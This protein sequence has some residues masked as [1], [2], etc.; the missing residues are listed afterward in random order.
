MFRRLLERFSRGKFFR[1]RLPSEF[2][3][4]SI[5]V[6]PDSALGYL[7]PWWDEGSAQLMSVAGRFVVPGSTVWDI[8]SNVGVFAIAAAHKA[9]ANS[10]VL[11]VEPDPFLAHLVQRSVL[12]SD[13]RD[14]RISVLCQAI[15]NSS[16]ISRFVIAERGRSTNALEVSRRGT[17]SGGHVPHRLMQYVPTT[18]LDSLRPHFGSPDFIKVDVEGAEALVLEG[19]EE[20]LS[21][22]RPVLYVEVSSEQCHR[23][24]DVLKRHRYRL[25]NGDASDECELDKS[26]WNTIAVPDESALTNRGYNHAMQR[27]AEGRR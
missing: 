7:K 10:K 21:A 2:A 23:V 5:Y 1:K 6:S 20:V 3:S 13:N 16:G 8:G 24:T 4:R 18:T 19:A 11:A 22:C 25:Y 17:Q 9:G 26:P 14:L 15:S 12:H 27:T